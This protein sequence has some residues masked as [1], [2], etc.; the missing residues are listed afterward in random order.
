MSVA[1]S[2]GPFRNDLPD[3]LGRDPHHW[4]LLNARAGSRWGDGLRAGGD[5]RRRRH[6]LYISERSRDDP[7]AAEHR[8]VA[9]LVADSHER[10]CDGDRDWRDL[11]SRIHR[12]PAPSNAPHLAPFRADRRGIPGGSG[13]G[14]VPSTN[15]TAV[16]SQRRR[17]VQDSR[18]GARL[19]HPS[20][21]VATVGNRGGRRWGRQF[22]RPSFPWGSRPRLR[23]SAPNRG[24]RRHVRRGFE[25]EDRRVAAL[26]GGRRVRVGSGH[27]V[28]WS[29][30]PPGR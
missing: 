24:L 13:H 2:I 22:G 15:A 4:I 18:R 30:L 9:S 23:P 28:P 7:F 27:R 16:R 26:C 1:V 12:R 21:A 5:A 19:R 29:G 14:L 25:A 6:L 3:E 8:P 20:V 17:A 11:E 10:D